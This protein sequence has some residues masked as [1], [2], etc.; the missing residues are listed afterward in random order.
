MDLDILKKV[1]GKAGDLSQVK[2]D[3]QL[4]RTEADEVM[5]EILGKTRGL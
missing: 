1:A 3:I 5:K 2:D 4:L